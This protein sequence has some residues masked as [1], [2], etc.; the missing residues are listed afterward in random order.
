[1]FPECPT[2]AVDPPP[3]SYSAN[4]ILPGHALN[5]D[6][7]QHLKDSKHI[8]VYHRGRFY[9][10][11]LYHNGRLLKP[12]EIQTQM[13]KILDDQSPAQPGEEKLAALTAGD[14]VPWAKARRSF[15][16]QGK[17]KVSLDTI[18]K[19][20]FFVTL[21]DTEQGFRKED[22]MTSLDSYAKSLLH[23]KCYDRSV[24]GM[25]LEVTKQGENLGL[26][27]QKAVGRRLR[28]MIKMYNIMRGTDRVNGEQLFSL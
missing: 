15:F 8:A 10:V 26:G 11:W 9:K 21:D 3:P 25:E 2:T 5:K 4:P 28:D 13:Q 23:G 22:P 16:S 12:R 1:M 18:E 20:A 19:A 6:T 7:L 24:T 27:P 17:N 14:R